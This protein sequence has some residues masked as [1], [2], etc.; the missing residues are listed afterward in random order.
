M[1]FTALSPPSPI[2]VLAAAILLASWIAAP[3][4]TVLLQAGRSGR[5]PSGHRYS[6]KAA[7]E[8]VVELPRLLLVDHPR[9]RSKQQLRQY[10][11]FVH[12][13]F[14]AEVK[15]VSILDHV[16]HASKG[17]GG[18]GDPMGDLII[19]FGAEAEIAAQ[20]RDGIHRFQL[21]AIDIDVSCGVGGIGR[22]LM[23]HN[24]FLSVYA[25]SEVVTGGSEEV[26]APLHFLFCHQASLR[27][28]CWLDDDEED[29]DDDGG[30]D[31]DD[32]EN[33]DDADD[34]DDDDGG[35]GGGGDDDDGDDDDKRKRNRHL[36]DNHKSISLLNIAGTIFAL[37]LLN[38]LN[39]H[40]EQGLLPEIQCGF[41]RDRGKTDM[42]FAECQEMRTHFYTTFV[43]LTNA[44]ETVNC[45]GLWKVIQKFGCPERFMHMANGR[46]RQ[47]QKSGTDNSFIDGP[48]PTITNAI[49]LHPPPAPNM[50][51]NTTCPTST[52]SVT[53]SDYLL[54]ATSN[55]TTSSACLCTNNQT[56]PIST[57]NSANPTSDSSTLIP[58]INSIAPTIIETA[59]LFS[60]P[61]TP[62]TAFAFTTT[63][64]ISDGDSLL[65]CPQCDRTFT[66][67]IGLV[68][69][70]RIYRA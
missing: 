54:P 44:F 16:L 41:H 50:A 45:D 59:S 49:L 24:R 13:E 60:S 52:T 2:L 36:C 18:F 33:D 42:I 11:S 31:D 19:D 68:G 43:D 53:T 66:S 46:R 47:R 58:V 55:T 25:K 4:F 1:E 8:E 3:V 12:L 28:I 29:D 56:I 21:G 64:T 61:I 23:H 34:D 7:E 67:R 40:L 70:L 26:H 65:N 20:V 63:T 14:D 51:M 37:I 5:G 35:G 27:C 39:G 38:R 9:F 69:H 6:A 30:G 22:R 62:T 17:L 32:D 10:H 57:S 48:P 15:T